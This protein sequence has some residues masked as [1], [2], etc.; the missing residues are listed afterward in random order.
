V[1]SSSLATIVDTMREVYRNKNLEPPVLN[2]ET[3]LDNSIGLDSMD[4][5]E[6]V[7]R[8]E[9]KFG[10]DPFASGTPPRLQKIGDLVDFY[11]R[12]P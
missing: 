7:V 9:S 4:F 2:A 8:L 11:Q 1:D 10:F 5:A 3:P 6:L 12:R